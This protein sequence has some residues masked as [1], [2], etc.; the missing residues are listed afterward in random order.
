MQVGV[1]TTSWYRNTQVAF[2]IHISPLVF[3]AAVWVDR[4]HY[5]RERYPGGGQAKTQN[6][7][8]SFVIGVSLIRTL[9]PI[10][11]I[12]SVSIHY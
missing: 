10:L 1:V 6:V 7:T 8:V 9:F 5:F 11:S 12:F 4:S 3:H 2:F